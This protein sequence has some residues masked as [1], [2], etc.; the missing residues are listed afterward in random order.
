MPLLRRGRQQR[1]LRAP[2]Q[3]N[4]PSDL[5]KLWQLDDPFGKQSMSIQRPDAFQLREIEYLQDAVR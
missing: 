3:I 5:Y 4:A 1:R 2:L